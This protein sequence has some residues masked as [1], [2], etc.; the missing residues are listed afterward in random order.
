MHIC[1][2]LQIKVEVCFPFINLLSLVLFIS[3]VFTASRHQLA[4]SPS[5]QKEFPV[6][7]FYV[8]VCVLVWV[9]VF[10]TLGA[11][12]VGLSPCWHGQCDSDI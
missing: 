9:W 1:L 5:C 10:L 4:V 12:G 3:A 11:S 8:C 7:V 2:T 6:W